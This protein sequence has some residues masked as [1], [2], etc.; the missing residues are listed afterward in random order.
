MT[1]LVEKCTQL[2]NSHL[3]PLLKEILN[4]ESRFYNLPLKPEELISENSEFVQ[5]SN[6][7]QKYQQI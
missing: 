7:E 5:N 3:I 4:T 6:H 1:G 2:E